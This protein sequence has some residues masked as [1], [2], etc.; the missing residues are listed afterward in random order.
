MLLL[1]TVLSLVPSAVIIPIQGTSEWTVK[2]D[3]AVSNP[4]T[5]SLTQIMALSNSTV[6]A[7][8]YCYGAYVTGGNWTGVNLLHIL[9]F[10]QLEQNADSLSFSASDGYN[11]VISISEAM[12]ENVIISYEFNGNPL[13]ETLRL[14]IPEANGEFWVAMIN[15]IEVSTN[16]VASICSGPSVSLPTVIPQSPTPEPSLEVSPTPTPTFSPDPTST[17]QQTPIP[18]Q[19]PSLQQKYQ[20]K[21]LSPTII[22][23]TFV[24][25][26]AVVSLGL[27]FYSKKRKH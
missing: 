21:E 23:V 14:V 10:V 3:G 12:Q 8:L 25:A 2:I 4:T 17:P 6:Y 18:S 16:S 19:E 13:P 24:F 27:L 1:A 20:P 5:L 11:R 15:H 9:E 22:V 26:I 7:E